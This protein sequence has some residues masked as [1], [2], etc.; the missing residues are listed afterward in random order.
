LRLESMKKI[1]DD[2]WEPPDASHN[3]KPIEYEINEN[4]CWICVS[5]G[6][7]HPKRRPRVKRNSKMFNIPRLSYEFHNNEKIP[8][9]MYIL[10]SCDNKKCLNPAH[11]R[12]GDQQENMDDAKERNRVNRERKRLDEVSAY[13]IKYLIASRMFSDREIAEQ[14]GVQ[15]KTVRS[16]RIG[17]RWFDLVCETNFSDKHLSKAKMNQKKLLSREEKLEV[18]RLLSEGYGT[19]ELAERFGVSTSTIKHIRRNYE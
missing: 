3:H 5:H 17:K 19:G 18:K 13:Q 15:Q 6:N 16:I 9:G 8:E 1:F 7:Y 10:H 11:L 2:G 12:V 4:G 14:Y